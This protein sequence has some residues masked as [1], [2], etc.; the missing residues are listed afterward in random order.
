[1]I[2]PFFEARGLWGVVRREERNGQ[3]VYIYKI[4]KADSTLEE[5]EIPYG[6]AFDLAYQVKEHRNETSEAAHLS[7]R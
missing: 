3:I 2:T 7:L 6:V 4:E 1:M 5:V